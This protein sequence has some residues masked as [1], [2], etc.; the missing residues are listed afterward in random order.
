MT[1][2]RRIACGFWLVAT[3]ALSS[4]YFLRPELIDPA[5]LVGM[6]RQSG[7]LVLLAYALV[8]VLRPVTLVPSTV[9]IVAGTLLFPER[10][11]LVFSVSL[12]AVVA[13]AAIIYYFFDFLGLAELFERRHAAR[14]RWLEE[15]V[16]A[17]G[18]W[19][20]AGWSAFPFVPTDVICYAAGSLRMPI[21]KFLLGVAIGEIPIVAFYVAGG[22]W[23]FSG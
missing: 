20:V 7:P 12:A 8:S 2:G 9:L 13:S 11:A 15:Q 22:T 10:Y 17:R 21:G 3:L 18:F 4:L 23:L 6:L 14:V 5:N 1:T 19:I 16:R